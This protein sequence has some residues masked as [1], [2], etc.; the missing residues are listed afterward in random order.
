ADDVA[1][2]V[3]A[4]VRR[5][6]RGGRRHERA[7]GDRGAAGG[8]AVG[9]DRVGQA[10]RRGTAVG[11]IEPRAR[12]LPDVPAVVGVDLAVVDL[13]PVVV[14]DVVDA[15]LAGAGAEG[16]AEGVAQAAGEGL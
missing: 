13:L 3:R 2:E 4:V 16:D 6:P 1:V 11:G 8:V 14:A 5:R 10:R 15:E 9:I 7:A 12:P